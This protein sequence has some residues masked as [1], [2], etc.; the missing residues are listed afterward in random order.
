M[1]LVQ[2][3]AAFLQDL[4][5]SERV[6]AANHGQA[7]LNAFIRHT[8]FRSGAVY[9]REK[10]DSALRLSASER[11]SAPDALPADAPYDISILSGLPIDPRPQA[12]VPVRIQAELTALIALS[13]D[14]A[15]VTED[16]L[17]LL[18]AVEAFLGA[19]MSN[20]RLLLETREGD[21][22]LK[23]RLW[24]LE[25]L[26][27]IG[28][29]IASTLNIDEL[30]D[31]ILFRMISLTNARRAALFLREGADF[32]LYRSFGHVRTGFLD[33]QL[34]EQLARQGTPLSFRE[35]TDCIFPGCSAFVALPIKGNNNSLIGV[36]GAADRETRDGGIGEFEE[37][38]LRL[39]SLFASQASIALENARL[40]R[41]ALDKQAMERDL[42]LAATIQRDILPK[43]IPSVDGLEIAIHSRAARQ[44]G[45]DYHAFFQREG[46]LTIVVADVAGKSMPAALLVSALHAA[47]QLLFA[48]GRELADVATQLNMHIHRWS[49]EN[50]FATMIVVAIDR[51]TE[52]IQYVNAGHN[53][54]YIVRGEEI[55]ELRSQGLP[56]GILPGT[57]Y[58]SQTLPFPPGSLLVVY[59]DGITEAE[60]V[61]EEEFGNERL[62]AIMRAD[63][64]ATAARIRDRV[65]EAVDVFTAGTPQKD[66]QTLVIIRSIAPPRLLQPES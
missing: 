46:T 62:E 37:N 61:A 32:K 24:E 63:S 48:E 6:T 50:K 58:A 45:G 49:A 25:S 12:V 5:G 65:A 19:V 20:H 30:A 64:A 17:E 7:I 59:S 26:Y 43:A 8:P 11:C 53:P 10:G 36:L 31:E 22:Q 15:D 55:A 54:G 9:V 57:R 29:S 52:T 51:E 60:N 41:E 13:K 14:G 16:D 2:N 1:P 3:L 33:D 34:R 47:T 35:N 42:E 28:L 23:Y 18:S 39:L 44:V 4:R 27:D 40:H 38:E 66:D 21:F 56:I